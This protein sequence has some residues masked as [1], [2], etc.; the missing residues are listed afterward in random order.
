L[1]FDELVVEN[2]QLRAAIEQRTAEL[3][4]VT[5]VQQALA[6]RLDMQGLYDAVGDKI[7]ELFHENDLSLRVIDRQTGMV[8]IPYI[9]EL[10]E[11]MTIGP[12]PVSGTMAHVLR[13][14]QTLVINENMEEEAAR[15]G[16]PVLDGTASEKSGAWVPLRWGGEIRGLITSHNYAR[17]HAFGESD[18][19][20][21]ETLASALSAA[22]Q[23]A[24][25]FAETQ[26]LFDESEQRAAELAIVNSVQ[27]A[28]ASELNMQGIY[29]AVGHKIREMFHDAD[30]DIRIVNPVSGMVEF[31]FVYDKGERVTIEPVPAGGVTAHVMRTRATL[32]VNTDLDQRMSEV[33]ASPATRL[34]GTSSDE[35]SAV[36]VPLVW[37]GEARGLV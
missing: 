3:A 33:G 4:V 28:L 31:P 13:I 20:L 14:G 21:L 26:R 32:V 29:D 34:P 1:D 24:E 18:V 27:Q 25:L 2:E 7:R 37:G 12:V 17:E 8:H 6:S 11:R 10:G 30:I 36:W 23:N 5:S 19:R 22:L 35:K 16:A 9:Y 15:I